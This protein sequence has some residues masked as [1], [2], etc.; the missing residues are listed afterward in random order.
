M[1]TLKK[2]ISEHLRY[3]NTIFKLA[4]SD[5]VKTYKG[6][7][8]GWWWA[9]IRP[10]ITLAVYYFAFT[11]GLKVSSSVG[12]YSYFLWL[13]AG[14]LPWFYMR[15]VLVAGAGSIKKYRFLVT[16]IKYPISTIPTFVSLSHLFTEI[17]LLVIVMAIFIFSG[18]MPDIYWLQLPFYMLLM[19]VLFC[20]WS[21]FSGI[22]STF[23]SDFFQLVKSVTL[24][25]FW[26]SG[27]MY[28]VH[29]IDNDVIRHIMLLNP[30]TVIVNGFRNSFIY[31]EW[32]WENSKEL[33]GFFAVTVV[34]LALTV[35]VY[36]KLNREVVDIL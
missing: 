9:I 28:D 8:L 16:K 34:L 30:I 32:F 2:I 14:F 27:I 3:K 35:F 6:T 25:L 17:M 1:K 15:D 26:L 21:L 19:F 11:V 7:A 24:M 33:I 22:L 20:I 36:K 10:S 29:S 18:K 31:K 12:G 5:L 4:K 13:I 23:S